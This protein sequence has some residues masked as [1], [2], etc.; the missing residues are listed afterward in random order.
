MMTT[1]AQRIDQH[2]ADSAR[3]HRSAQAWSLVLICLGVLMVA[4]LM[5]R[6]LWPPDQAQLQQRD[7]SGTPA[8]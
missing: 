1:S 5:W 6:G 3:H 2:L 7:A 8:G 4:V